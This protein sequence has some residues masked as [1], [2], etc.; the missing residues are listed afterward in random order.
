MFGMRLSPTVSVI[1]Q[2]ATLLQHRSTKKRCSFVIM[3]AKFTR[4]SVQQNGSCP[5]E[6]VTPFVPKL[7]RSDYRVQT[8]EPLRAKMLP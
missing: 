7:T 6:D 8:L 2:R 3:F 1:S 4:T 5:P